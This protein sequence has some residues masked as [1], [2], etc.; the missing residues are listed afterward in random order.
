[1]KEMKYFLFIMIFI[2]SYG[3]AQIID[4]TSFESFSNG[5]EFKPNDW[6]VA[7]F[8]PEWTNN[9]NGFSQ[10]RV[11]VDDSYSAVGSKSMRVVYPA[12]VYG[13]NSTGAQEPLRFAPANQ[14][15]ASYWVRFDN[16]FSWGG[17]N[18]NGKLPGLAG[19]SRCSGGN[20]CDGTEG[21][22]ARVVWKSGGLASLY[23]YHMDKPGLYGEYMDFKKNGNNVYF[24]RGQWVH[25]AQRVKINTVSNGNANYNGEVEIW[26][27]GEQV[28]NKTGLRFV[29][30]GD[31]VDNLYFSTFHGG[32]SSSYSPQNY[33]EAW[34][35]DIRIGRNYS[36]VSMNGG[37]GTPNPPQGNGGLPVVAWTASSSDGNIPQNTYDDNLNTRWSADGSGQWLTHELDDDYLVQSVDLAFYN[38]NQRS[39]TFDI[40]VSSN[41]SNWNSVFSGSSSGTTL[42]FQN[43]NFPDQNAR[44]VRYKGYGNSV[45]SWNSITEFRINGTL[46]QSNVAVSGVSLSPSSLTLIVG[47]D[48]DLFES[49]SPSNATNKNVSWSSNN[50]SVATVNSNGNVTAVAVGTATITVTTNDGSFTDTSIITVNNAGNPSQGNGGLPVVAWTASGIDGNNIPQNTYDDD[51]NTRWSADGSGQWLTH[52]LDDDYLVQSVDLAFYR[53][54]QRSSTFD[55]EVSSNGS[56]WNSVFSGSS[57]GTTLNFQNFDF[58]DQNARYVRYKGYGNSVNSWNSLTEFR[59][60]GTLSQGSVSVN[61]VSLSQTSLN[62]TVGANIDL[63]ESVSPSNATNKNV[64][65]S[66]NNTSV[67]TVNS[68]GNVTAVAVGTATITVTTNDGSYTDGTIVTVNQSSSPG[69]RYLRYT[70]TSANNFKLLELDWKVGSLSVPSGNMTS[71]NSAG[72]TA[73]G[74]SGSNSWKSF[75][76]QSTSSGGLW[77]GTGTSL[78]HQVVLDLGVGN[79][80]SPTAI[81]I[82]RFSYAQLNGFKAEGSNDGSNWTLLLQENNANG[83]FTSEGSYYSDTFLFTNSSKSQMTRGTKAEV[84]KEIDGFSDSPNHLVEGLAIYPNPVSTGRLTIAY[85]NWEKSNLKLFSLNGSLLIEKVMTNS[86]VELEV[87]KLPSGIYLLKISSP[88]NIISR[89]VVIK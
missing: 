19:G 62:L 74:S 54:N 71:N 51:L 87:K 25:V 43:F 53:G 72:L 26:I 31:K 52:E 83:N 48:S 17:S 45:N 66:S 69:Y 4:Q 89:K 9:V 11:Y 82:H 18:Q 41:G 35:D 47:A 49:V 33:S 6:S 3:S 29:T 46:A 80:S 75:D 57:S 78:N 15:Y 28:L 42:N 21:F 10:G 73:S 24:G 63:I 77:V 40:E 44:Y 36:D 34:F 38:G 5:H 12:N 50:T 88:E 23:L 58:P 16:N 61:G 64:S 55:I 70:T 13:P 79:E 84:T 81:V 7:G 60:N 22:T 32:G 2:A 39:S 65:W 56:N 1:M 27:N 67:A 59:I 30:N 68:N 86:Q 14:M 76:G 20:Y 37:G 8:D 85:E